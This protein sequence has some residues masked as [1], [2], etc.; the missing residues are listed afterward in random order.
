MGEQCNMYLYIHSNVEFE[1]CYPNSGV[2]TT[3]DKRLVT[4]RIENISLHMPTKGGVIFQ[5]YQF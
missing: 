5:L 3:H 4:R 2:T 1:R